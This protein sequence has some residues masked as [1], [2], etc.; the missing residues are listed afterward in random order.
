MGLGWGS[1]CTEG[2]KKVVKESPKGVEGLVEFGCVCVCV[3]G[4]RK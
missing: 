4:R 3:C 2:K 1:G